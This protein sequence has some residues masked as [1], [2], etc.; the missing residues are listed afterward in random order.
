M[1]AKMKFEVEATLRNEIGKGASRRLRHE[2]KVPAIVYGG[3]KDP[4][5]LTLEHNKISKS[6]EAEAFYSHILT[7][8]I[9][10]DSERVILKDVQR[11]PYRAKITHVDFQRVRAD[12]KLH[13]HVPLHFVGAESCPGAKEGGVISHILSDVEVACLPDNLPEYI[14]V[15]VAEL[16]LN[17]I[18]HL[19][20]LT[21]PTGVE[22]PAL[23]HGDD[24]PVVSVHIPRVEAEPEPEVEAAEGEA[25]PAAEVPATSQKSEDADAGDKKD[26]KK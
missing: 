11:H 10:K 12:Q 17:Q 18:I 14:E 20:E 21:L 24:K 25:V 8:R 15:N 22:L 2:D 13:M 4:V 16:A 26:S 19:S 23:L 1:S 3:G 7:L 9:N 5:S 6:L